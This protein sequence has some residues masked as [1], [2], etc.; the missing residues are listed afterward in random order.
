MYSCH[1][2]NKLWIAREAGKSSASKAGYHAQTTLTSTNDPAFV[3][4]TQC[5]RRYDRKRQKAVDCKD[6][7]PLHLP[8]QITT[9]TN[10]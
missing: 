2:I 8:Q 10:I 9:H 7:T 3:P 1:D 6:Y 5:S 4:E